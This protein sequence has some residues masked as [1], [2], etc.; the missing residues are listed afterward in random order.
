MAQIVFLTVFLGLVSGIQTVDLQVDP[1]VKSVQLQLGGRRVATLS[2]T[3]WSAQLDLGPELVPMELVAVGY[4]AQGFEIARASQ[5]LNLPR[6]A[7]ELAIVI[8]TEKDRQVVAELLGRHRM[9]IPARRATLLVDAAAVHVG[10]DFRAK[11]PRL[12][13]SHPHVVSGEMIF[14]DGQVARRDVVIHGGFSDSVGSELTPVLVTTTR[15]QT[16]K[17]LEGCFSANG[18]LLRASAIEKTNALVTM[19][20][21]PD[22]SEVIVRLHPEI[23]TTKPRWWTDRAL[24]RELRLDADTTERIL[25][26]VTKKFS[27][28][29]EP[30]ALLFEP[31]DDISASEGG[32]S[33]LLTREYRPVPDETTPRQYADAVAVAGVKSLV[34]GRRR[35]VV[36]VLGQARDQ[37]HNSPAVVRRYLERIGVPL[38]VWSVEGPR[39]DL[40][41]SWGRVE[42]VSTTAGLR[43]A[44]AKLNNALKEQRIA[45]IAADPLAA[46][47]VEGNERCGL[48]PVAGIH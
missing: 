1:A 20:K 2:G 25:W 46:L 23:P 35:A 22:A 30:T 13:W 38:F 16:P 33:W 26:P 9:H 10:D 44:T 7:A 32:V 34:R 4:D 31:S 17:S 19:V 24:R 11:L 42:D 48:M 41:G 18:V 27:A 3:P 47:K 40:R 5:V 12:D 29:G 43:E 6:P 36:L 21:D 28:P 45:W 8:K 15:Q 39:P 14:E 37:S